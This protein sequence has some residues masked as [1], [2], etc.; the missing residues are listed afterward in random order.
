MA[1]DVTDLT[2]ETEVLARSDERP[3]VIDLWA[4]WCGPCRTL[5]PILE[6]VIDATEGAVELVKVNVDENPQVASA[7]QVQSIP[8]VFAVHERKVVDGFI[9]ALPQAQVQEFVDR[10][11]GAKS[12][13]D[14][15]VEA[16]DED[17]LRHALELEPMNEAATAKLAEILVDRG[18]AEEALALLAKVPETAEIRHVAAKARLASNEETELLAPEQL[19]VRLNELID[20][21][22]TDEVARQEYLDILETLDAEDPRRDHY[23]RLLS[24]RLF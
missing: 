10:V 2:F 6:Q 11:A 17:S 14:L 1:T 24:A 22:K 18:E 8:A 19:E 7:F 12:E 13:I 3:I 23:R 9:G 15:L 5:G 4:P 20:Q 21:V 16:G